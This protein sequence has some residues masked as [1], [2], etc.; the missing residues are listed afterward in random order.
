MFCRGRYFR[1]KQRLLF[2][3]AAGR[4]FGGEKVKTGERYL[5]KLGVSQRGSKLSGSFWAGLEDILKHC[6]F[7]V[8]RE[9]T[10]EGHLQVCPL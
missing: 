4:Y 9:L 5:R 6:I 2:G 3:G 7:E 8:E 1:G 10:T